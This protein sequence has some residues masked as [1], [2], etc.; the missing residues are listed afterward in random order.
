LGVTFAGEYLRVSNKSRNTRF[1]QTF[2]AYSCAVFLG[3][4]LSSSYSGIATKALFILIPVVTLKIAR[5]RTRNA[6]DF[7]KF[8]AEAASASTH[9]LVER[10]LDSHSRYIDIVSRA[11]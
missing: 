7:I 6:S 5:A 4:Y 11:S 10:D 1:L 8:P 3:V 2:G 9:E